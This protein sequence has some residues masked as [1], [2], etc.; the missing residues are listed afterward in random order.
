MKYITRG[1][2]TLVS[3]VKVGGKMNILDEKKNSF[4]HSKFKL[5]RQIKGNLINNCDIFK[6]CNLCL[7]L[8]L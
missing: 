3:R 7:R 1:V 4:L 2:A 5:L 8:P 6:V